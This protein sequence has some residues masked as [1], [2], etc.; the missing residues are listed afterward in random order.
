MAHEAVLKSPL[1]AMQGTT[2]L[3]LTRPRK[4]TL[5][6]GE[7]ERLNGSTV[8][9]L[10]LSPATPEDLFGRRGHSEIGCCSM[11]MALIC[12]GRSLRR[13]A[14]RHRRSLLNRT[15]FIAVCTYM[16]EELEVVALN[17]GITGNDDVRKLIS[18]ACFI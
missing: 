5:A 13:L 8:F 9:W 4:L 14:G 6:G 16:T 12:G 3:L 10:V 1:N 15:A 2:T 18:I 11:F 17:L 7:A